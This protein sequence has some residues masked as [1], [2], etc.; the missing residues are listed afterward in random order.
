MNYESKFLF[1]IHGVTIVN[2]DSECV[3]C[4]IEI[5]AKQTLSF[6]SKSQNLLG[7]KM[8]LLHQPKIFVYFNTKT[9]SECVCALRN[10]KSSAQNLYIL[11]NLDIYKIIYCC[12]VTKF[13]VLV[14]VLILVLIFGSH[15]S[16]L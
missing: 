1:K 14:L 3:G 6:H 4:C 7:N 13:K 11:I 15:G 8:N 5:R 12:C 16:Q 10:A 2:V 9:G